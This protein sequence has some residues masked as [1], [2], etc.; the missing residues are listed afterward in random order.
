MNKIKIHFIGISG[1]GMSGIAE[2][3]LD[4]GF[5]IQGSD[6]SLN[7]NTKRLK[8]K[9]VNFFL[10]HNK[11]NIKNADVVVYSSAIKKNNPEIKEASKRKIPLLSRADMLAELMKNKKCIAIAGSHGKTTTTSLI[12]TILDQAKLDP[13]IVNGGIINSYSKNNR[14]GKGEWMV[15]EADESDGSFLKLPH[16]ISIITNLDIEH[17]DFYKKKENLFKAFEDFINKLPFYGKSIICVDDINLNNITK[18]I[19]NREIITYSIKNK[20]A[21]V[22]INIVKKTKTYTDFELKINKKIFKNNQKKKYRIN[23]IGDHNILNASASIIVSKLININYISINTALKK[24]IGVKRR[25]TFLGKKKLSSIYDDYAHHPTEIRATINAAKNINKNLVVVY[26]PH[27]YSRTKFLIKEFVDTLS[28]I[29]N[30]I[31]LD[32][33]SAGEKKIKGYASSDLNKKIKKNNDNV[34]YLDNEKKLNTVLSKYLDTDC[35]ILFMG[36]GSITKLARDFF[37]S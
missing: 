27:R 13:T 17:M 15:V 36:A 3:M 6:K 30:L 14:Y 31:L 8:K 29:K 18:K 9:G 2:L 26:Q 16:E 23:T 11:S 5:D 22:K 37:L 4:R 24:Y 7:E 33:Y 12:G 21:D 28:K 10:N 20:N 35:L 19:K 25:F 32:T 34:I 1:I